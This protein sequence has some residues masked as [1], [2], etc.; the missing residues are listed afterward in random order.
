MSNGQSQSPSE[1]VLFARV[2]RQIGI[3]PATAEQLAEAGEFLPPIWLGSGAICSGAMLTTGLPQSAQRAQQWQPRCLRHAVAVE[4]APPP[5]SLSC[6]APSAGRTLA[7]GAAPCRDASH[8]SA[9]QPSRIAS[10][11]LLRRPPWL[12]CARCPQRRAE[13]ASG[14]NPSRSLPSIGWPRM[15]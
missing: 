3:S 4:P 7:L 8:A 1:L 10:P 2:A 6:C 11:V 14:P 12:R 5:P 15:A 9:R 13:A